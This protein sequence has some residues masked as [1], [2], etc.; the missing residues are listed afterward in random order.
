MGAKLMDYYQ[1]ASAAGGLKGRM[2]MAV[3]TKISSQKA[4]TEP[5]SP[6]NLRLFEEALKEI[7]NEN[8]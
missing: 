5:D 3:I 6:E 7:Q 4:E 1:K 8:K 2:R